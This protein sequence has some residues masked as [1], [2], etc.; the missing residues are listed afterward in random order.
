M[1]CSIQSRFH[2]HG[3]GGEGRYRRNKT[4]MNRLS[5]RHEVFISP[6]FEEGGEGFNFDPFFC[7]AVLKSRNRT[8]GGEESAV[9]SAPALE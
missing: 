5:V 8:L 9:I 1:R 3:V 7:Q 2:R 6:G 4:R